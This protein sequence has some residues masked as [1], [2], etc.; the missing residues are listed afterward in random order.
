MRT[1]SFIRYIPSIQSNPYSI[2][3]LWD[4]AD[5]ETNGPEE[6]PQSSQS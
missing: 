6:S 2:I 4:E 5:F 3:I 1:F